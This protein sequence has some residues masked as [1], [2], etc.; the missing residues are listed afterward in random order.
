MI[1]PENNLSIQI[2]ENIIKKEYKDT[3]ILCEKSPCKSEEELRC[4]LV[5][6][7]KL[8]NKCYKCK[9]NP[10]WNG[11]PLDFIIERKNNKKDDN[12]L[13]NLRFICPNCYYQKSNKSIYEKK[14][15]KM[16]NCVD[17]GKR[18]RKKVQKI[19][20]NPRCEIIDTQIKHKYTKTRCDFCMR[21]KIIEVEE[22]INGDFVVKI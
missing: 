21:K 5:M 1:M 20:L 12:T 13:K 4:F 15:D 22:N 8:E 16:T 19:S 18:M 2:I 17:C 11:K 7:N 10:E 14:N 9:I 3:N 6:H